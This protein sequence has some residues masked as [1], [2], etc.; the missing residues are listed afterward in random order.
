M[1]PVHVCSARFYRTFGMPQVEYEVLL[2]GEKF[3]CD[4]ATLDR[5]YEGVDPD[6]LDLIVVDEVD[7]D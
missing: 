3:R 2:D 6:S 7:D 1:T 4:E 5:L